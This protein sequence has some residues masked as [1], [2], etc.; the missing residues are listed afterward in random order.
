VKGWLRP[1]SEKL[2]V[3]T[4]MAFFLAQLG[5]PANLLYPPSS[6][7]SDLM[8][9]HWPNAQLVRQSVWRD[10]TWP[11]W[12]PM[13]FAG[14]PF[15]ANPLS[16]LWY[17]PNL[18]LLILPLSLAFNLLLLF[19]LCLG[20]LG[21]IALVR[22]LGGGGSGPLLA[23]LAWAL[24][25]KVWAHLGAGHVGLVY[26]AGWL[27]WVF[28]A[29][30][31]L[32]GS[33]S[34]VGCFRLS[35]LWA[36]QFLA[37]PRLAAYTAILVGAA[38]LWWT[39]RHQP[40]DLLPTTGSVGWCR[41]GP[42]EK[43][44]RWFSDR[45]CLLGSWLAAGLLALGLTAVQWLPLLDYLPT[46]HRAGLTA[47]QSAVYSLPPLQLLG[48]LY[49]KRGGFHE[50]VIY[51]GITV[52][53]LAVLGWLLLGRPA[54]WGVAS[55][56]SLLVL[57]SLGERTP[58]YGWVSSLPGMTS[59]RVPPRVWFLVSFGLVVLAGL[60][61][62]ALTGRQGG[63]FSRYPRGLNR[64]A[65]VGLGA[66]ASMA[67]GLLFIE[68]AQALA[69]AAWMA[70]FWSLFLVVICVASRRGGWPAHITGGLVLL[71]VGAEL[72]WAD[73][74]L[75][76]RRPAEQLL[77]DGWETGTHLTEEAGRI[78]APSFRPPPQVA[79]ELGLRVVN[80][81]EPLQP[82]AYVTFLS[83]AAGVPA[84]ADYS[85]TLPA[86]PLD[87]EGG[88]LAVSSALADAQPSPWLLAVLDVRAVV[89]QFT[90]QVP[91]LT[92]EYHNGREE[93]YV[94]GNRATIDWPA[95]FQRVISV[96]DLDAA[97][98]RLEEGDLSREAVVVGGRSL[99]GPPGYT[100][101]DLLL[102]T[103]NR[104][105]VGATGPGLLILSEYHHPGWHATV[106]GSPA[107]IVGADGVLRGVYLGEGEHQVDMVYRPKAVT[108][109][110]GISA[111]SWL[112]ICVSWLLRRR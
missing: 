44:F 59:L 12:N 41:G 76:V 11:L 1:S 17:P 67:V 6:P 97:L 28:A 66:T 108:W 85:I 31:K 25:P 55:G 8:L 70:F 106:D 54:R 18:V 47:G 99:D 40:A 80:G 73:S 95:V 42:R 112:I 62:E 9:T 93:L 33:P 3:L 32:A 102:S 46:T 77:A 89:S 104:L 81:V 105:V 56:L 36:L 65:V 51:V 101:A 107:E 86:L 110:L 38:A 88:D 52:L 16:G 87:E 29:A 57:F 79:T 49:A 34:W 30:V 92:E 69:G 43:A 98:A 82:A 13:Q 45:L 90:L 14:L 100:Q 5:R 7:Y 103:P 94:Y 71:L 15:A 53:G 58:L 20:G 27:P 35:L 24:T 21:M 75:V 4:V 78:Y 64:L 19:H 23:G 48:L 63:V 22:G 91:W 37:D 2:L 111:L 61:V 109:G 39:A 74:S 10:H 96:P 68:E 72:V 84:P 50:W 60:G 26:A 83:A